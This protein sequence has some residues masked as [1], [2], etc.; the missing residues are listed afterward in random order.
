M[1]IPIEH[2]PVTTHDFRAVFKVLGGIDGHQRGVDDAET[3]ML[4]ARTGR[5]SRAQV[6][7]ATLALSSSF[8]GYRVQPGHMTEQINRN[9]DKIR[10]FW[11]CPDPPRELADDPAGE[12]AWRRWAA[13]NYAERALIA[14]A[15]G[16]QLDDVPL[17]L[18]AEPPRA[19]LEV[20]K[21]R[22]RRSI[23]HLADGKR[24]PEPEEPAPGRTRDPERMATAR[25]EIAAR[26]PGEIPAQHTER[27]GESRT[28]EPA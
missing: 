12:L 6:A 27:S 13:D 5:W 17:T 16:D 1:P 4:A 23:E 22:L 10:A 20:R 2:T 3:W 19:A 21:D 25:R 7:A 15:N 24:M 26:R 18:E 14:L 9:R 11:Y 8:T 28:E